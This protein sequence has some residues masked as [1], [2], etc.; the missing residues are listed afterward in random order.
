[1]DDELRG[2]LG[3]AAPTKAELSEV[4]DSLLPCAGSRKARRA[5]EFGDGRAASLLESL[6]RGQ[7]MLLGL[8]SPELQVPFH[9]ENGFIGNVDFYWPELDL[10]GESDGD[11]KYDGDTSPSGR[12]S[13]EVIEVEKNR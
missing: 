13:R 1:E 12:P 11:W 6:S 5:I 7:I 3:V 9:D 10:I 8:P 2:A 4:L